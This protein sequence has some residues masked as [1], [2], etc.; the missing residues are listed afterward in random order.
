MNETGGVVCGPFINGPD[1]H[2][3]IASGIDQQVPPTCILEICGIQQNVGTGGEGQIVLHGQATFRQVEIP[4]LSAQRHIEPG[5]TVDL[6]NCQIYVRQEDLRTS[7]DSEFSVI[8]GEVIIVHVSPGIAVRG[9]TED[10]PTRGDAVQVGSCPQIVSK[11]HIRGT[12]VNVA[13][14]CQNK[15][16]I[17]VAGIV[18]NVELSTS[19]VEER[20]RLNSQRVFLID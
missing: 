10:A 20:S 13:C 14:S 5:P 1:C 3:D 16:F 15:P 19:Q 18:G 12:Q 6:R 8:T 7:R 2:S 4:A 17:S 11:G 9:I